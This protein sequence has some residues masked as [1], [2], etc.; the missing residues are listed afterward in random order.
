MPC[1]TS[2]SSLPTRPAGLDFW[3]PQGLREEPRTQS[4][5]TTTHSAFLPR[6]LLLSSHLFKSLL[7]PLHSLTSK[8]NQNAG[9][10]LLTGE[11]YAFQVP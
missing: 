4:G 5:S 6:G 7:W 3:G 10:L 9:P 8:K 11:W 1:S 2:R